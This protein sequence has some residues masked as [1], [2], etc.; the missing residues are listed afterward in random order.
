MPPLHLLVHADSPENA[1]LI[2]QALRAGA[3]ACTVQIVSDSAALQPNANGMV[4]VSP[5]T[6]VSTAAAHQPSMSSTI[7]HELNNHL[8]IIRMLADYLIADHKLP[9]VAVAKV[10]EIGNAAEAAAK[11]VRQTKPPQ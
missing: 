7:R 11:A 3:P 6:Q 9:A 1:A 4:A 2:E 8:G 5:T 10:R